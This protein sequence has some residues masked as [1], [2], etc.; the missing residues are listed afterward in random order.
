MRAVGFMDVMKIGAVKV[1]VDGWKAYRCESVEGGFLV[2]GCVP[3]GTY[4]RGKNKGRPRF[5]RPQS[6][7]TKDVIVSDADCDAHVLE[8]EA[9]GKCF[10]C[11][12]T[13]QAW[14]GW[15]KDAGN[16]YRD[17]RRCG[18]TGVAR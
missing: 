9:D 14:F 16:R 10:D 8:Y 18:A 11:S 12:G 3:D 5:R 15:S 1:S 13:G 2:R 4:P 7:T 17:C 6:G